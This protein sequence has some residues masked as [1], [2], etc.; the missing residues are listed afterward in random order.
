MKIA[1][2][3]GDFGRYIDHIP[4]RVKE[5]KD[6]KFRYINLE[7]TGTAAEYLCES[8][9]EYKK[10]AEEFRKAAEYANVKYVVS[11]AP[12]L[13]AYAKND[14]SHYNTVIR[15]IRRSIEVCHLLDI[16]RIVVHS[17][18]VSGAT[19]EEFLEKNKKFYSEFFDLMEKYN[20][21][22]L[23]ENWDNSGHPYAT[24][25]DLRNIVDY[26]DHPLLGICWDTAHGNISPAAKKLGQY[27][28]LLDCGDKLKGL[29][30]SDNFGDTHQHSWPFAGTINFDSVIQ[31]LLDVNYDGF[32]TFEASYTLLHQY[33]LPLAGYP[34]ER[35]SWEYKG[36]KVTKLLNPTV[37]LKKKA[38]DLLYDIGEHILKTYDC[39]EE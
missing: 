8:D 22:V 37:E 31:G 25:K 19:E 1:T 34:Y 14:E 10:L 18:P 35:K 2:S 24:G 32:F 5:F 3:T 6:T 13:N 12:C 27:Q 20:I 33:N 17:C 9:D 23:T 30:I 11:H 38:V 36:E 15:A 39:F 16:P 4:D 26:I 28:N 29:H 7:Q 21:W